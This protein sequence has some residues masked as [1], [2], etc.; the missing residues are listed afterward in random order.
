[1]EIVKK[2]LIVDDDPL[3]REGLHMVLTKVGFAVVEAASGEDALKEAALASFDIALVDFLMPD[4]D[5]MEVLH[6]LKKINPR[7]RFI[8]MTAFATI[9][10]AVR[11]IKK[12]ASDYIAK[13]VPFD[14]LISV[15]NRV[16]AESQFDD[17]MRIDDL[18]QALLAV[19]NPIRRQVVTLL[20]RRGPQRVTEMT[21]E[22]TMK[23]H[24]K[25]L[26][27][28]RN[29][30]EIGIVQQL[31]AKSY[32]LTDIGQELVHGLQDLQNRIGPLS[33]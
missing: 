8:I 23:D 11:A 26:F 10:H 4:M 21:R 13:P 18:D 25:L 2:I 1:M 7:S 9:E 32:Y 16:L 6:E 5:G 19:S 27:H 14:Q 28:I 20:A 3:F 30:K 22:L 24:T 29:L 33:R 12:G 17:S 15:I 31:P